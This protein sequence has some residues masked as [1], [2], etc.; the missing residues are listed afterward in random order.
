MSDSSRNSPGHRSP[1][2]SV[3]IPT[4]NSA[5]Y[6]AH[7]IDSA[8]RQTVADLEVVV[9]DDASTDGTVDAIESIRDSRLKYFRQDRRVGVASN[10]NSC[11]AVARGEYIAWL[12]SDDWYYPH[13]L[14][15]QSA[16]LDRHCDVGLAHAG[17]E[18]VDADG[19]RLPDWPQ[20]FDRDRVESG[21]EAFGELVLSNYITA[22]TVLVRRSCHEQAGPYATDIGKASTDWEM[23]L[24][25]SLKGDV[26]YTAQT[27]AQYRYHADSISA[28][29]L[30]A[31]ERL[32]C[33]IRATHRV[34]AKC[35]S[36][37]PDRRTLEARTQDALAGKAL[38][39]A[40]DA[41]TLGRQRATLSGL[42][43]A[44]RVSRVVRRSPNSWFLLLHGLWGNEY[45]YYRRSKSLL[46][47]IHAGL[48]GTKY[49]AAIQKVAV[50]DPTWQ[51]TLSEIAEVVRRLVPPGGRVA[52][53]DKCDPTLLHL[54]GR[55]GWH[56]P[57][58]PL[59][60]DGYPRDSQVAIEHLEELM[61][62]GAGY[63]VFPSAAFWWL[64]HYVGLRQWLDTRGVRTWSD[65]R[66]VL[67]QL[68][69]A[70]PVS[71]DVA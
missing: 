16:V 65:D 29:A 4:H 41:F 44:L 68:P 14:E 3:C 7:A 67:Y 19:H 48:A 66:C 34:F 32:R 17:F 53:V 56:F 37:I 39:Y 13:M 42:V 5:R 63:I 12:D 8:L 1:K 31:G 26:A 35:G 10:R 52:T 20:P 71:R 54:S 55:K 46:A 59:L 40:G 15:V 38:L 11:L 23:W 21:R 69:A 60:P 6:L 24:R 33:D 49:G 18:V 43:Q 58:R 27:L 64:D 45:A 28:V 22:P 62:R 47:S 36:L 30:A 61:R 25:L 9:F 2:I 70:R 57:H 50:T 51:Q